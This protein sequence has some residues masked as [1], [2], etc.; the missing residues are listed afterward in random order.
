L[1]GTN[2]WS[3]SSIGEISDPSATVTS[4]A[5]KPMA[6]SVVNAS[7]T[8]ARSARSVR[9]IEGGAGD[10]TRPR[11]RASSWRRGVSR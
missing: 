5:P 7:V 4:V 2:A 3:S 6:A 9:A 1:H 10:D 11:A 8:I